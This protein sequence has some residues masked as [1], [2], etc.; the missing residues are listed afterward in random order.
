MP[1]KDKEQQR[2]WYKEWQRKHREKGLCILCNNQ[3]LFPFLKCYHCL[4][5][6]RQRCRRYRT[7]HPERFRESYRK[8]RAKWREEGRCMVCGGP[9]D[10]ENLLTC[11]NCSMVT[12]KQYP[13]GGIRRLRETYYKATSKLT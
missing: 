4:V 5:N 1:Y 7:N 13:I 11:I 6:S 10:D 3:A 12:N 8:T 2:L 9:R